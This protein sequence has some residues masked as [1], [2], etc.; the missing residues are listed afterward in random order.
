MPCTQVDLARDAQATR[1]WQ[2]TADPRLSHRHDRVRVNG[3]YDAPRDSLATTPHELAIE[4]PQINRASRT[5]VAIGRQSST[6]RSASRTSST[7]SA[8]LDSA[9]VRCGVV[10]VP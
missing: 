5:V 4:V 3:T 6:C 8:S 7:L 2:V 10:S 1:G 9:T